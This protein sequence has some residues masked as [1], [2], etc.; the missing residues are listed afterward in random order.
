M[1]VTA[2]SAALLVREQSSCLPSALSFA[3]P[4]AH[5]QGSCHI[6]A[7]DSAHKDVVGSGAVAAGRRGADPLAAGTFPLASVSLRLW[8]GLRLTSTQQDA[9]IR[10]TFNQIDQ[11]GKV[12]T[13]SPTL[14]TCLQL[15]PP[16]WQRPHTFLY[17]SY[18]LTG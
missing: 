7:H 11:G 13:W 12:G 17:S 16:G 8:D 9:S 10:Q 6:A 15:P 1:F 18:M 3:L 4:T 5:Q 14:P 2:G